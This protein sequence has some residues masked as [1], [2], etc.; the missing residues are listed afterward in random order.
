MK[1]VAAYSPTRF[2]IARC[3]HFLPCLAFCRRRR[4]SHRRR[5]PSRIENSPG[6]EKATVTVRGCT[7]IN[8]LYLERLEILF[9]RI[10]VRIAVGTT[11]SVVSPR[12]YIY[13]CDEIILQE[14]RICNMTIAKLSFKIVFS[15]ST[16]HQ[17]ILCTITYFL[18]YMAKLS[19][20]RYNE[21]IHN[22]IL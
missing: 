18:L 2:S 10:A 16:M 22:V 17:Y 4:E 1:Q 19:L 9:L 7:G 13:G 21:I 14:Y 3:H 6:K 12:I 8:T 15:S 20:D 11:R 5:L